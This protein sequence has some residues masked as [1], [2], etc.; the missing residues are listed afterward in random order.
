MRPL[1]LLLVSL[2]AFAQQEEDFRVYTES[3]R[4]F[5]RPQRLRLVQREKERQ[6]IRWQQFEALMVGKAPM[7]EAGFA[8][9]LF[10]Q[11]TKDKSY[12]A[13]AERAVGN[14]TR[15][16][17]IVFDWCGA[18]AALTAKLKVSAERLASANDVPSLRTRALAAV[19][20][21]EADPAWS[22]AAMKDV[23][24]RGWRGTIVPSIRAGKP[25][26][27]AHTLALFELLHVVRD[28]LNIDLRDPV[29]GLF[30]D[31]PV[32][33][34]LSYYPAAYPGAENEFR[35]PYYTSDGE[36]DLKIA[37]ESRAAELAMVAF[38]NNPVEIQ[39]LQSW[40]LQ[41]RYL[42]RGTF[43]IVYEYL[44]ANPYQPGI[45][46]HYLPNVFHD[47][48]G[49]RLF[50][51]SNWEEDATY[52]VYDNGA[53]QVF[54]NGKRADVNVAAQA[55]PIRIGAATIV[56]GK[57]PMKI[58]TGY[59]VEERGNQPLEPGEKRIEED[60]FV[61]GLKPGARYDIEADDEELAEGFAD[62]GGTLAL[63]YSFPRTMTVRIRETSVSRP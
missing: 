46:Y 16:M 34:L 52:F 29:Q 53:G 61:V 19:A 33:M 39:S 24:V 63:H 14:D 45:T 10:A 36:P 6:S 17:A 28:N 37:A 47:K 7:P 25:I 5:L 51:R 38:D 20:L 1:A 40:L 31:L 62:A 8:N 32:L 44:W 57:T 48:R 9:A 27:R 35:V 50:I 13:A 22:E 42:M 30:R 55:K 41:D 54:V 23:V 60:W 59:T 2:S 11:T 3:P 18:P 26:P 43:G 15:Q 58:E 49:G 56:L 21:A 12:C 4:I